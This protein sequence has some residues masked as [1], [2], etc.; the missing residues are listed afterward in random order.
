MTWIKMLF[1]LTLFVTYIFTFCGQNNPI[2]PCET[3]SLKI[4]STMVDS[5]WPTFV[6]F[7]LFQKGWHDNVLPLIESNLIILPNGV[8]KFASLVFLA[9][10]WMAMSCKNPINSS[11][12]P[13]FHSSYLSTSP[14]LWCNFLLLSSLG[15][16]W[17]PHKRAMS[18]NLPLLRYRRQSGCKKLNRAK[19]SWQGWWWSL[20]P[21][22]WQ[23][24]VWCNKIIYICWQFWFDINVGIAHHQLWR[25]YRIPL[26]GITFLLSTFLVSFLSQFNQ[27]QDRKCEVFKCN[28]KQTQVDFESR[29]TFHW[30]DASSAP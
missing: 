14:L 6:L 3:F 29:K 21:K 24:P 18:M 22:A 28:D 15:I 11:S 25:S 7:L 30:G 23:R 4:R 13:R 9:S 26:L 2:P 8:R 27:L 17:W 16:G 5:F 10:V 12:W 19:S 1:M 20:T